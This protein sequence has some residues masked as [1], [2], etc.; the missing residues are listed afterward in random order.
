[1]F[2][3]RLW[4]RPEHAAARAAIDDFLTPVGPV[5]LEVGFD[6]GMVLLDAAR[7]DPSSRWLGCELRRARVDAIRP[8]A[9]PNCLPVRADVR[10]LLTGVIPA[11]RLS[12]VLVL[13][14]TPA[15]RAG[16]LWLTDDVVAALGVALAPSGWV[17]VATDVAPLF[18]WVAERF[19][20][21]PPA[22]APPRGPTLSRR[23]RVC[24][25][26]GLAVHAGTWGRPPSGDDTG[27]DSR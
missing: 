8:L 6:H 14:P 26:D 5:F 12:G 3:S 15:S 21:W 13:F 9:P 7:V 27:A 1:M 18:A 16:H 11:G 24:R 20:G 17:H 2:G 19:A 10:G 23:E 25:R 4:S 22:A